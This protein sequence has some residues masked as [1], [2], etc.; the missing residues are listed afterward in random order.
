MKTP[1]GLESQAPNM[2]CKLEKS[3][4]GLKQAS[5][6]WNAKLSQTL[7]AFGYEQSKADYSLF[8]KK[9]P[10][11]FTVILVYVDDLVLAGSDISEI[12]QIKALL[13]NKFS[14]KDLGELKYFLGFEIARSQSGINMCQRKYA[15][16]LLQDSGQL[17]SKPCN[18][19]MDPSV[20][21]SKESGT[22]LADPSSYRRLIGW[23]L[24]L[25]NTRPD[26]CYA[27]TRLS[28]YMDTP[29]TVHQQ[30]AY[31]ILRYIKT[32]PGL[33]LFFPKESDLNLKGFTDSDWGACHDTH[34][35]TSG[36]CFFLGSSL[37]SWKSKKQT[38][39]SRYPQKQSI[40]LLLK[41][42]VKH[43]GYCIFFM[44]FASIILK[45]WLYIVTINQQFTLL[46]ILLFMSVQS[47]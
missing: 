38:V 4:Y 21:I 17:A 5:R 44:I 43:N 31:R 28:Q 27:V 9:T 11:G 39:V 25:T 20:T 40:E 36:F 26:I 35:S 34:R 42:L 7:I 23:L 46:I 30:A 10:S 12:Q 18:T 45:L 13:H 22:Q 8:T 29:T 2:V 47:I 32:A 33:G 16:D 3:L 6:Q 19:P 37:V 24:Y 14:I 1:P 15:L 41:A